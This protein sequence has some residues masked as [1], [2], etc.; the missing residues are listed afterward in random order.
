MS[1]SG[2]D[3]ARTADHFST[4]LISEA[5]GCSAMSENWILGKPMV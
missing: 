1:D 3:I 2:L 5:I 4:L